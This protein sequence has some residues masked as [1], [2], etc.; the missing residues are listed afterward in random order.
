MSD[1]REVLAGHVHEALGL[2]D[3]GAAN[4][5]ERDEMLT[6]ADAIIGALPGLG[7]TPPQPPEQEDF[8]DPSPWL[9]ESGERQN[10]SVVPFVFGRRN[11]AEY[12]PRTAAQYR[13]SNG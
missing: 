10:T 8:D 12:K 2:D 9:T 11:Y 7:Y 5:D 13:A 1:I 6:V 3:F 4:D